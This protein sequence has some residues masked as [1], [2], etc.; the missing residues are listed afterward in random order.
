M[1]IKETRKISALDLR[2]LC[3]ERNWY[4]RGDCEEYENLLFN[5]ADSKENI[6]TED[7]VAIA[8]DIMEH[9][10]IDGEE[11]EDICFSVAR[12]AVSHFKAE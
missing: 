9:S 10:D 11:T 4:T 5:L 7:I 8:E 3:I 6:T 12:I 2:K 1:K